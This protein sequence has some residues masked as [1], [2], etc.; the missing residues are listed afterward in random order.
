MDD[1]NKACF[2]LIPIISIPK[3]SNLLLYGI[4]TSNSDDLIISYKKI[5]MNDNIIKNGKYID[6]NIYISTSKEQ[7]IKN[8]L[9]ISNSD[10][11][12]KDNENI[13]IKIESPE[14]GTI[15]LIHTFK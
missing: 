3:N 13:L 10:M 7:F 15:T 14:P 6:D 8:M 4:S 11:N 5:K 12:L 9:Y 2:F 1:I